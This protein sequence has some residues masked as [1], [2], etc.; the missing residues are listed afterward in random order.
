[1][2]YIKKIFEDVNIINGLTP[3]DIY[4]VLDRNDFEIIELFMR[5]ED[6]QKR[7]EAMDKINNDNLNQGRKDYLKYSRYYSY[8]L[9]KAI[10]EIKKYVADANT[11]QDASY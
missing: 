3:F 10:D 7:S 1:M 6:A 8:R 9:D 4:C 2:K 5:E 11:E